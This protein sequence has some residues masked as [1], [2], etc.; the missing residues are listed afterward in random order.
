MVNP[1]SISND[2]RVRRIGEESCN[3][4][5]AVVSRMCDSPIVFELLIVLLFTA[6]S[7]SR[8]YEV[9]PSMITSIQFQ[10]E[11]LGV[12]VVGKELF[13]AL[14][15][16]SSEIKVHNTDT[17]SLQTSIKV[18]GMSFPWDMAADDTSLFVS[19][20]FNNN[21]HRIKLPEKR[22][23]T[24]WQTADSENGLSITKQGSVLVTCFRLNKLF[25]YSTDGIM[26]RKIVLQS[27]I[28]EPYRAIQ[29]DNDQFL[30][31]HESMHRV[32][33]IDNNGKLIKSFGGT[34]GTK[35]GPLDRPRQLV[36]DQDGFILVA[37]R[38]NNRVVLLDSNL[39]F[40]KNLIPPSA[41]IDG[42][43]ALHLAEQH[44]KLYVSNDI[45]HKLSVFQL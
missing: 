4:L 18:P 30:M 6:K 41:G 23:I 34:T 10:T 16:N 40:V 26:R 38:G 35:G 39:E 7:C 29:L 28:K 8:S 15:N 1:S 37:D 9:T 45:N 22:T 14:Y 43:L 44:G 5:L 17:Y 3:S 32:C 42:I 12:V 25:E 11:V 20:R 27:D 21:I 31:S 19:E 2:W 33:L 36:V 13:V 24:C